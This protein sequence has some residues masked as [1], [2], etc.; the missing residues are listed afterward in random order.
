[1]AENNSD[2]NHPPINN[3]ENQSSRREGSFSPTTITP[4]CQFF[5]A[6]DDEQEQG[7][8]IILFRAQSLTSLKTYL[9]QDINGGLAFSRCLNGRFPLFKTLVH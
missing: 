4:E 3:N 5:I 2:K 8:K 1:M 6:T 9:L 7:K